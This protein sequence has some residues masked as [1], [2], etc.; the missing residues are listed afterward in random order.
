MSQP[1]AKRPALRNEDGTITTPV[2]QANLPDD[3]LVDIACVVYAECPRIR[4][5]SRAFKNYFTGPAAKAAVSKFVAWEHGIWCFKS[6]VAD[7][8]KRMIEYC[9]HCGKIKDQRAHLGK[10]TKDWPLA[11]FG[12]IPLP[13][14]S[15]RLF[16]IFQWL[17]ECEFLPIQSMNAE[18]LFTPVDESSVCVCFGV[19][20]TPGL[21]AGVI[22]HWCRLLQEF[23]GHIKA[24][25]HVGNIDICFNLLGIRSSYAIMRY[26]IDLEVDT[27]LGGARP[28]VLSFGNWQDYPFRW[29]LPHANALKLALEDGVGNLLEYFKYFLL[30]PTIG[31]IWKRGPRLLCQ[32]NANQRQDCYASSL[33][34]Q[35]G[36]RPKVVEWNRN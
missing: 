34:T 18:M 19:A 30:H 11:N 28:T 31:T 36:K 5:V 13:I 9:K 7:I 35:G 33:I 21:Q 24:S 14:D 3:I 1:E 17:V 26:S 32:F 12:A 23:F 22:P 29:C 10:W 16:R 2:L 25:T 4:I 8:K 6:R 27:D 20:R 15:P